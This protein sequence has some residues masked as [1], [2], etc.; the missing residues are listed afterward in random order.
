MQRK[1]API[2]KRHL[3][4]PRQV[5]TPEPGFFRLRLTKGGPYFGARI[6]Y[7]PSP[8]WIKAGV[9]RVWEWGESIS[10]EEYQALIERSREERRTMDFQ[11]FNEGMEL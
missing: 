4:P 10:E 7:E 1:P 5:N 9:D 8:D 6:V 3:E 11:D 2:N